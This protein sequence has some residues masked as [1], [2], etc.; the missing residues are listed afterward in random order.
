MDSGGRFVVVWEDDK[1]SNGKYQIYARGF[2]ANG[3]QRFRDMTVNSVA[4]GQ[5]LR[6]GIAMDALGR[7]VVVWQDDKDSNGVYQI[8]AR[9]FDPLG[10]E[11][12]HDRTINKNSSGQQFLPAA[13]IGKD[14]RFVVCWQ[15][16]LDGNKFYE[17][18]ARGLTPDG[19]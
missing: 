16:D 1:D 3:A 2:H 14:L 13:G 15:D 19:R 10:R 18:L 5:Q 7:Y 17:I 12:F 4:A 6:P 11:R 8:Y 9:G